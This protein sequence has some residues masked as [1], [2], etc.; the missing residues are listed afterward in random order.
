MSAVSFGAIGV[1][2]AES[3]K[4][5]QR[6]LVSILG[7]FVATVYVEQIIGNGV[8]SQVLNDVITGSPAQCVNVQGAFMIQNQ[9]NADMPVRIRCTSWVSGT[10]VC[11]LTPMTMPASVL[12][13]P[14]GDATFAPGTLAVVEE[15]TGALHRT[16]LFFN[17]Y[18]MTLLDAQNGVGS[19]IYR[20][21][22]GRILVHGATGSIAPTTTSAL[23]TSL[24]TGVTYNWGLGTTTQANGTLATTEQDVLPTT[25]GVASATINTAPAVSNGKLAAAAQFDGTATRKDVYLNIG[26][27]TATDIDGDATILV[28]GVVVITWSQLGDY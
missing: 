2:Q 19:R 12:S 17:N 26:L 24:N 16:T 18:A 5:G 20:F 23:A 4:P 8:A 3:L 11:T 6:A 21:P 28:N 1:G 14:V 25:A 27:A 13:D 7:T 15:H 22:E 10:P 9:G